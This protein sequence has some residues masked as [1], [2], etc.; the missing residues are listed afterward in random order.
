[1]VTLLNAMSQKEAKYGMA[2]ICIGGGE[3]SAVIVE[4]LC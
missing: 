4:N 1:M 3:A 2:S